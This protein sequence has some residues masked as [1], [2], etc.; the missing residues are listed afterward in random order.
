MPV[1]QT[2]LL[3]WM[4]EIWMKRHS[5]SDIYCDIINLL[6]PK[7]IIQQ[8]MTNIVKFAYRVGDSTWAGVRDDSKLLDDGGEIPKSQGR[9]WRFGCRP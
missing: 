9:S 3:S 8:G 4:T 7:I 5:S 1:I 2:K 6:Y